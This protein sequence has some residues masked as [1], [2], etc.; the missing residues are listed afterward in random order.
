MTMTNTG[1]KRFAG[2]AAKNCATGWARLAQA[3]R[4]PSQ[5]PIGTQIRLARIIRTM[6]R[7]KVTQ[8]SKTAW[9]RSDHA[10]SAA[11]N[12]KARQQ[13]HATN[14]Q[15]NTPQTTLIARDWRSGRRHGSAP[16][17]SRSP[18]N[19]DAAWPMESPTRLNSRG[20][21][22]RRSTQGSAAVAPAVVSKRNFADQ[23]TNGRNNNW[24]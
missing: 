23:A 9:P 5:T 20:R 21:R 14:P 24:S 6:T 8:P 22:I 16:N 15:T 4:R 19:V 18:P 10:S 2:N 3:G 7:T 11:A 13:A 12:V 17:E 1:K